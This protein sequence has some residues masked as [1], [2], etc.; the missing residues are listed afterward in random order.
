MCAFHQLCR[1]S[2]RPFAEELP[3]AD[4]AA[5]AAELPGDETA[6]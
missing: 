6:T 3:V 5:N 2:G 1:G 4:R